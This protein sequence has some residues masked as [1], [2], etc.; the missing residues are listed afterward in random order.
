MSQM[1]R[2][3]SLGGSAAN[4]RASLAPQRQSMAPS[5]KRQSMAPKSRKSM[6]GRKSASR[7]SPS[8]PRPP[9][10]SRPLGPTAPRAVQKLGGLTDTRRPY[11]RRSLV[12]DAAP[13]KK[14]D[15]RPIK[16]KKFMSESIKQVIRFLTEQGARLRPEPCAP[17]ATHLDTPAARP[18]YEQQ[19]SP[20]ILKTPTSKDFRDIFSFLCSC[21]DPNHKPKENIQEEVTTMMAQMKYPFTISKSALQSV[22]S[23][24]TWPHLLAV[25]QW[26]IELLEYDSGVQ[27]QADDFEEEDSE[28]FFFGHLVRAYDAFMSGADDE[29]GAQDAELEERFEMRN[30]AVQADL[31]RLDEENAALRAEIEKLQSQ[32]AEVQAN[33]ARRDEM[34]N[35]VQSFQ[36]LC[37]QLT[38]HKAKMEETLEEK[39]GEVAEAKAE[40]EERQRERDELGEMVS[41]QEMSVGDVQ[42]LQHDKATMDE[43]LRRAQEEKENCDDELRECEAAVKAVTDALDEAIQAYHKRAEALKL[44]PQTAKYADGVD[45]SIKFDRMAEVGEMVDK[46]LKHDIKPRLGEVKQRL[47]NKCHEVEDEKYDATEKVSSL[48]P[49]GLWLCSQPCP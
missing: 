28:K 8:P 23:P 32:E 19:I 34:R 15:P 7:C 43:N 1:R 9:P 22:G 4:S 3:S 10:P 11:R 47:V 16:D 49:P 46:D 48:L 33:E 35:D 20:K 36:K 37:A 17:R 18:G 29:D 27:D 6:G 40:L 44:L 31:E 30:E 12:G 41:Q 39:R 42:R 45:F 5:K 21:Y 2:M 26:M 24:H 38:T 25:L 14:T 13:R